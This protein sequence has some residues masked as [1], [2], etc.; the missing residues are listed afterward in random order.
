MG[1]G[2]LVEI[3][4]TV[5]VKEV[6]LS[7]FHIVEGR[8]RWNSLSPIGKSTTVGVGSQHNKSR[9]RLDLQQFDFEFTFGVSRVVEDV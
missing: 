2:S 1:C 4:G 5:G 8:M 9:M 3:A 7:N 6:D